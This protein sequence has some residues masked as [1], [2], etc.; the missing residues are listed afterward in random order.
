MSEQPALSVTA[1]DE[2]NPT[3]NGVRP[4]TAPGVPPWAEH[5]T[6]LLDDAIR[7]PGTQFRIG[8][9]GIIGALLPTAGDALTAIGSISILA[10]AVRQGV[11]TSVLLRM[12]LNIALDAVVGMFP[13]V[14]DLFDFAY[15]SNRKNLELLKLHAVGGHAGLRPVDIAIV[16]LGLLVLAI[17]L[18]LPLFLWVAL[19]RMFQQV[20]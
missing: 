2:A 13:V 19:F 10:L 8:F 18:V 4:E 1:R 7:I 12:L 3:G 14:G 16:G 11:P 20:T 17:C 5:V 6:R 9:D 15:K